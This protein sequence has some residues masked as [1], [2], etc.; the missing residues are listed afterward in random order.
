LA[1]SAPPDC[2]LL[3]GTEK[4]GKPCETLLGPALMLLFV[5][6]NTSLLIALL[7]HGYGLVRTEI[8]FTAEFQP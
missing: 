7:K 2:C 4:L 5:H 8:Q 6:R 3:R 1:I